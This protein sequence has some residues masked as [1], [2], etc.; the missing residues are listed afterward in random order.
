VSKGAKEVLVHFS[1]PESDGGSPV[2]T[3][4]ARCIDVPAGTQLGGEVQA[5]ASPIAFPSELLKGKA[6]SFE[7]WA[8]NA[9]GRGPAVSTPQPVVVPKSGWLFGCCGGR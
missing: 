2:V 8:E 4:K 3:Y 7:V 1:A 9:H 5:L 6:C